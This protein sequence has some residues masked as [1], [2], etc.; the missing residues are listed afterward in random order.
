MVTFDVC[1]KHQVSTSVW[2][3]RIDKKEVKGVIMDAISEMSDV[4]DEESEA[5]SD[6]EKKKKKR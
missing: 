5:G 1:N 3:S 6:K 2:I 4:E